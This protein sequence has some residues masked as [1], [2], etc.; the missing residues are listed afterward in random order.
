MASS[1]AIQITGTPSGSRTEALAPIANGKSAM[2]IT[3]KTSITPR[4][5]RFCHAIRRS[6]SIC[7]KN[8]F[9][10]PAR[11]NA[12]IAALPPRQNQ[13]ALLPAPCRQPSPVFLQYR[14]ECGLMPDLGRHWVRPKARGCQPVPAPIGQVLTGGAGRVI[15]PAPADRQTGWWQ[16][17]IALYQWQFLLSKTY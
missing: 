10:S 15:K 2:M 5:W 11:A 4:S 16:S 13:D 9:M 8:G 12:M 17:W 6:R 7:A 3:K 1:A 14:Q